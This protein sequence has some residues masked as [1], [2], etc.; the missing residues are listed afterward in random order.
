[1]KGR[2]DQEDGAERRQL[3][4]LLDQ[5]AAQGARIPFWWRD[6]D[7]ETATPA[8]DRLLDLRARHNVPLALAVVP[9]HATER[10]A[11]RIRENEDVVVLQHGWQHRNHAP[12]GEKK[13]ELGAH[14]PAPV[15][16]EELR[17]GFDRLAALM[18]KRFLP[19]L[20]PPWNRVSEE[21]RNRRLE[22]GLAGLSVFGP[23]PSEDSHW[24]NTHLDIFEWRP[25]RRPLEPAT[26]YAA[27]SNEVRRRLTG[28]PEP[29]GIMTHHLVHQD[30][31]WSLLDDLFSL[32]ATHSAIVW[33]AA[34]ELFAIPTPAKT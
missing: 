2:A 4:E 18:P 14:R 15:M 19:V 25:A 21:V 16:L 22:V 27:L 33:P 28:D 30:E 26:A 1:M 5:A 11:Q 31:S 24:V 9:K 29:I 8:L 17:L 34:G 10:L 12:E 20:V 23:A 13:A 7:A 32:M 6:D 3:V